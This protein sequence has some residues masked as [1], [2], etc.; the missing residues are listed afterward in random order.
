NMEK[1]YFKRTVDA[2]LLAWS[3]EKPPDRKPL[4]L[5]GCRQVGKSSAVRHLG[6]RFKHFVE[7]NFDEKKEVKSF[8]ESSLSPREICEQLALYYHTPIIPGETLLFLDEIQSCQAALAKIRYFYETYP[9]LHVAAA[10][11]LLEFALEEIPSF[12]VGRIRSL[13]MYPFGFDEFLTALDEEALADAVKAA[14]PEK[15]LAGPIHQQL[16]GRLKIFLICGGMPEAVSQYVRK[17]DLLGG[18]L[19][20]NDLITALKADFA[21][22]RRRTPL[23]LLNEVFEAVMRQTDGK[24]VYERAAPGTSTGAVKQALDLLIMAGLVHP[25]THTGANGIPLGAEANRKYRRMIPCD[26]GLF[27]QALGLRAELL[28]AADFSAVNRGSLAEIF[29]G[30]ELLKAASCYTPRELF[31]WQRSAGSGS[32][33]GNAQVDFVIQ[34]GGGI[35]PIEVK[36]GTQGSMQSLRL[37][38][39]EK[40]LE[41]GVRTSL[42]NFG[43]YEDI[44]VYPLYAVGNL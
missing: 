20:L 18:E 10:G 9:E 44:D 25:V 8:F 30:L 13:F 36:A 1:R 24:F 27:L 33:R 21:K 4:L 42:E 6:K 23:L 40:R 34:K 29:T 12:G 35:I 22:Y 16:L 15:P 39:K 32:L 31:C 7:I 2:I 41:R 26:T 43:R 5:R 14:S 38:M 17:R 28:P 37:F 19:V 3:R 11:S